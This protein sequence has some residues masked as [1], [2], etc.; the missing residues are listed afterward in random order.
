M[1]DEKQKPFKK[2]DKPMELNAKVVVA[3]GVS[4]AG[5][6]YVALRVVVQHPTREDR[7]IDAGALFPD[8]FGRVFFEDYFQVNLALSPDD[9]K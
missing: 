8:D 6:S 4:K 7:E 1:A 5:N 2:P 3:P 9:L